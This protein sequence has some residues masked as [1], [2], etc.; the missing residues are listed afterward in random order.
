[1]ASRIEPLS[2]GVDIA[3]RRDVY[4]RSSLM[5]DFMIV[6]EGQTEDDYWRRRPDDQFCEYFDGL[7]YFHPPKNMTE[8]ELAASR[9]IYDRS[10][11]TGD[12]LVILEDQTSEDFELYAPEN[13]YCDYLEGRVYMPSPVSS[14]HQEHVGFFH[15][16]I[17]LFREPRGGWSLLFGPA[18][19]R[20]DE[21]H[22]PEPDLF[23]VPLHRS[24]GDPP[25]ALVIEILSSSNRSHDLVR[26]LKVY[27]DAGIPEIWFVDDR[28][29][30]L[31]VDRREG[32]SYHRE[33]YAEGVAA[34][35]ALPGFWIDVAWLWADPLPGASGCA[36]LI[37][38]SPPA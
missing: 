7:I 3:P 33:Q 22:K 2:A 5:G 19:L 31:I 34:S 38:A 4:D 15:T 36:Q 13:K 8:D 37:L 25:A 11:L 6:I 32:D 35:S 10:S 30:V 16:L 14:R 24:E 1:M 29:H 18:V 17:D 23:V 27:Q 28:D 12:F 9:G 21:E 26:K 20:I